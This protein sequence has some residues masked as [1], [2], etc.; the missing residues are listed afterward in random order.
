MCRE[1]QS[2]EQLRAWLALS[3]LLLTA[4][5]CATASPINPPE[6]YKGPVAESPLV[7]PSDYWIYQLANQSRTKTTK[8]MA[9]IGF[10][11]WIG[12]NWSFE[13]EALPAGQPVESKAHRVPSQISCAVIGFEEAHSRP[14]NVNVSVRFLATVTSLIA[15]IG[16]FGMRRM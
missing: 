7:Q 12:K 10:P 16:N 14:S 1:T 4:F 11:L 5:S 3:F 6:S 2:G 8:L 9:N 13:G 15:A